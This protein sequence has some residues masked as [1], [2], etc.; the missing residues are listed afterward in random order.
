MS[1]PFFS[2]LL[3]P[4]P[5]SCLANEGYLF[6]L[7]YRGI[8]SSTRSLLSRTFQAR[9]C[10][11][12]V[13]VA[14]D[15]LSEWTDDTLKRDSRDIILTHH[16]CNDMW[17]LFIRQHCMQTSW[18]VVI[19]LLMF[20][21]LPTL[22]DVCGKVTIGAV[23]ETG[24]CAG[25]FPRRRRGGDGRIKEGWCPLVAWWIHFV[26]CEVSNTIGRLRLFCK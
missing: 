21:Y 1:G 23:Y 11:F 14:N 20:L 16:P 8:A 15:V 9:P 2:S 19:G 5:L 12:N 10:G 25:C 6:C 26:I 7:K 4:H 24:E 13:N 17:I 22:L 18:K 3:N